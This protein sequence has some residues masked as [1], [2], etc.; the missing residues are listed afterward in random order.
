MPQHF[1]SDNNAGLCPPALQ[2]LIAA[3]AEGHASAYGDDAWTA[4]ARDAIRTLLDAPGAAVFFAFNGTA[5]NSLALAQFS[6]PYHAVIAHARSHIAT[7]EAGA[8]GFFSG[9]G[10]LKTADPAD[11]KLS[12]ADV[13]ALAG[14]G[15]GAHHVKP[16]MLSLTQSTELGTVYR[17]TEI[18]ALAATA[19]R[20]GLVVHL[21]GARLANAVATLGCAPAD[22][23]WR[24]G[25]DVLCLGGVKNGLAAGEAIVFFN[26]AEA[27]EFEWRLKQAGHL[28]SK[29]R[30]VTAPWT[31]LIESG[32]WLANARHANAM[33]QDL[34]A[35]VRAI[36]AIT[37]LHPVE[38]NAVFVELPVAMQAALRAKGW[39]FY[40][41]SGETGCRLMCA[42]D[43][44][45]G[46]IERFAADLRAATSA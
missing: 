8:P 10:W 35:L 45:P 14:G 1:A 25:V 26:A 13:E 16:R 41:F 43:T 31:A 36:P 3:N 37:L 32:A 34:A 40:T 23:T 15:R 28:N 20:L 33:A 22:I 17:A 27:H 24:A 7:D 30:L 42:W 29:M 38:A 19:H 18:T 6:R 9:G 46:T 4:R 5:A 39:R 44:A 2:A 11:A 12:P 21:D